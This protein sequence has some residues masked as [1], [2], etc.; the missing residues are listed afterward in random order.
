MIGISRRLACK[1]IATVPA[2][3]SSLNPAT[4]V[5]T[6]K[7]RGKV[8][9]PI[10]DGSELMDTMY[11][12]YRI[13]E[14]EYEVVVCGPET[15]WYHLLLHEKPPNPDVPWDITREVTGYHLEATVAF[16]D[17]DPKECVGLYVSGGRAPEYLRYD[18]DLLAITKY[19]LESK[20]PVASLCHGVEILSASG[21]MGG[22][23]ATTIPKCALD[24]EQGGAKFVNKTCVVDGNLVTSRGKKDLPILLK[25]FMKMLNDYTSK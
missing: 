1:L 25:T 20:K 18:K 21:A 19:F 7:R 6:G 9:L 10:G 3:F 15:R 22:R 16:K 14:D 5:G 17:V 11:A 4:P 8:L 24:V 13:L 23:T 2:W 12:Y